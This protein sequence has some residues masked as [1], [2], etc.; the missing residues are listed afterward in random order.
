MINK[1]VK[2]IKLIDGAIETFKEL[3]KHGYSLHIVSGNIIDVIEKVCA[4]A[5]ISAEW[6]ILGQGEIWKDMFEFRK[7]MRCSSD[8]AYYENLNNEIPIPEEEELS[9]EIDF[10]LFINKIAEQAEEIGKLKERIAQLE[11]QLQKNVSN[12]NT[13]DI[14]SAG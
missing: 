5:N 2:N 10:S 11:L 6:L 12:A 9:S 7:P 4:N 14:A 3:K 13:G 8:P 1:L